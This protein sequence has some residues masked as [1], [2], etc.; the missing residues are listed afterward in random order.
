M[1]KCLACKKNESISDPT[2]GL[3]DCLDCQHSFSHIRP[4]EVIPDQ[5]KEDRKK[6]K[7]ATI[8]PFNRGRLSLEYIQKYGTK[9][10]KA[11]KQEIKSAKKV[12]GDLEY[13][14]D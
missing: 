6:Y 10:I 12:W 1:S 11:T 14:N 2:F 9:G 4:V 3:L 7:D 13:Y 5:L 8:Q